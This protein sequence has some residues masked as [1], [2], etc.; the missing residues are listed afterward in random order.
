M[1]FESHKMRTKSKRWALY[2]K[3]LAS[4][5]NFHVWTKEKIPVIWKFSNL[6]IS[7]I[8]WDFSINFGMWPLYVRGNKW[9]YKVQ[10]DSFHDICRSSHRIG[11]AVGGRVNIDT[12]WLGEWRL[13]ATLI[14]ITNNI[15]FLMYVKMYVDKPN[16][17]NL[18][19][20]L[21]SIYDHSL[22]DCM[23]H[24]LQNI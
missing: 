24:Q 22:S 6:N 18:K 8:F 10:N 11:Y 20:I 2:L 1:I 4:Y 9:Q 12:S 23:P 13:N 5:A 14:S 21:L 19:N 3:N 7:F 16:L 15:H 17:V